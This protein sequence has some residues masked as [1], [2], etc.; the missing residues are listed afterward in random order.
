MAH[1]H[2]HRE[3]QLGLPQ[4]RQLARQWTERARTEFGVEC[5]VLE[6]PV[7]DTVTFTRS[8]V[9]GALLVAA[10]HFT[11]DAKLGL[12][13]GAFSKKFEHEIEKTI[14]KLLLEGAAVSGPK[15]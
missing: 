3:H 2:I 14:D 7:S 13:F 1:I 15:G 5:Q 11:V 8:G 4:A 6:G 9:N 10:D 12:L